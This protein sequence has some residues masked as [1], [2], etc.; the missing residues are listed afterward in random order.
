MFLIGLIS[1]ATLLNWLE[2]AV[3]LG[4][5]IFVH[6]LGH[7]MVA[8]LCGVKCEKF[9]LGFDIGG[10]KLFSFRWGE[11]EYGI[12]I[13]PLGGYVK[14]LGQEDNPTK[15][16]DE[17]QRSKAHDAPPP[18]VEGWATDRTE[19]SEG[20]VHDPR[21]YLAQ[22]VPKRMAIIS[23]GVVMNLIFA[24]VM[25]TVAY[26]I[27]VTYMP[28]IVSGLVPGQPAWNAGMQLGD[29]ILSINKI[30]KPRFSDLLS[31]IALSD[32]DR[33]VRLTVARGDE[34]PFELLL[35]P[36]LSMGLPKIGI[37]PPRSLKLF[38]EVPAMPGSPAAIAEPALAGGD[39]IALIDGQEVN[40]YAELVRVLG[41]KRGEAIEVTVRRGTAETT[42]ADDAAEQVTTIIAPQPVVHFG[43]QLETG[44]ISAVQQ[45][46]PA[47]AAGFQVGDQIVAID[48]IP[49]GD[50]MTLPDRLYQRAGEEIRF[51]LQQGDN[52]PREVT[53]TVPAPED[54]EWPNTSVPRVPRAVEGLG[55]AY[56]MLNRVIAVEP[57]SPAE[58]AGI[59]VGDAIDQV[60]LVLPE[61]PADDV[62]RK[63]FDPKE[64]TIVEFDEANNW[65]YL[66][67]MA[68]RLPQG[69]KFK[70]MLHD[71]REVELTPVAAEGWYDPDRGL[72]LD[73][74]TA[75]RRAD[76][77]QQAVVMGWQET[78]RSTLQVYRFLQKLG[79]QIPLTELGGPGTIV[80]T[81]SAMASAGFSQFLIFLVILSANL[82]VL[83]FLPIPMLDGGHMVFLILEG[84]R[85]KP[86]SEKVVIAF[87][88]AGFLF[89]VTLMCFVLFLDIRR[90]LL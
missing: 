40:N 43:M 41:Q 49:P 73:A 80:S 77:L 79:R 54:V 76:G 47:E 25:G 4:L 12:G 57:G 66:M 75:E 88:Y 69:T 61:R 46:S 68:Q 17:V 50:G 65:V 56:P 32:V 23:A 70:F 36:T 86:V 81:A 62:A 38:D 59:R 5:V 11:T 74:L 35:K 20:V 10:L 53:V 78:L 1:V 58:E 18:P 24:V 6:E 82:A 15:A 72:L 39:V 34:P 64:T 9:Y 22:S 14:M 27:G 87:H 42:K 29:E 28:A 63:L 37:T 26:L 44:P 85:R 13:L 45:H 16:Y 21:S 19:E 30:Q 89:I 2:V 7:F 55:I 71:K 67:G 33:G 3:G 48:G 51:T 52:E 8:K 60:T 83:N 84:I 31:S 90:F